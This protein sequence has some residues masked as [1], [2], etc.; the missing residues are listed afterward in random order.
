M[1][2]NAYQASVAR[3]DW[4]PGFR[5]ILGTL[6][7]AAGGYVAS[8]REMAELAPGVA[9]SELVAE[10]GEQR[11]AVRGLMAEFLLIEASAIDG[12]GV[13]AD[14]LDADIAALCDVPAVQ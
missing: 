13:R 8:V 6:A 3:G 4:D 12:G 1:F 14:G 7:G 11:R 10:V 2:W 9:R 5:S